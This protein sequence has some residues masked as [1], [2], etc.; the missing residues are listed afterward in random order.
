MTVHTVDYKIPRRAKGRIGAQ[1]TDDISS[2]LWMNFEFTT[3]AAPKDGQ[4]GLS[5]A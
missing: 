1:R 5:H 4:R 2:I 3:W